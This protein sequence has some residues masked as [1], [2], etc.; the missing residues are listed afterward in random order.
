MSNPERYKEDLET[1]AAL[2]EKMKQDLTFRQR[3]SEGDLKKEERETALQIIGCF[4]QEYQQWYTEALTVV[5]HLLPARCLEFEQLYRGDPRRKGINSHTYAIQDWH[6]GRW[7]AA[8][9]F[10]EKD[11]DDFALISHKFNIQLGILQA[12]ESR[13][14]SSLFDIR[15][16]VQA[17][18]LRS[19]LDAAKELLE[20]T[21]LRG[22]GAL[23]GVVLQKHLV[24]VAESHDV[25]LGNCQRSV[26]DVAD[27][28]KQDGILDLSSWRELQRLVTVISLCEECNEE[29]LRHEDIEKLIFGVG[30]L[31]DSLP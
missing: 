6:E 10:G 31:T 19:E 12:A 26:S 1:L 11:F 3:H 22:A 28:L 17:D 5:T 14:N 8:D 15:R 25:D 23:A 30:K 21:F 2:G 16:Q 7:S 9:A 18:V 27:A 4:E 29:V 24:L 20:H 13:L